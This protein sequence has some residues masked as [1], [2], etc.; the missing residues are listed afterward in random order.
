MHSS[1]QFFLNGS[2]PGSHPISA[3][4]PLELEDAPS[5][6][7]TDS[8]RSASYSEEFLEALMIEEAIRLTSEKPR[9]ERH[10]S[11]AEAV[12]AQPTVQCLLH[13]FGVSNCS[14]RSA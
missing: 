14:R 9:W 1:L 2:Q 8:P 4:L 12:R 11:V 10:S 5:G 3:R 13:V 7:A 6:P